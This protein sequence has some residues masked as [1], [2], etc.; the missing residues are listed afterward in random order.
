MSDIHPIQ[1]AL[2]ELDKVRKL[3]SLS[4]REIG[5][6]LGDSEKRVHPQVVK[7]HLNQLISSGKLSEVDRP[8]SVSPRKLAEANM[9]VSQLIRLPILGAA[10]AGPATT[11]A[12]STIEGY[13]SVSP[14]LLRSRNYPELIVLR[15]K[16]NSMNQAEINGL[17]I[18]NGDFVIVDKSRR[19]PRNREIVVV[20]DGDNRV[21]IKRIYF[22]P[23]NGQIDLLSESS[24]SFEPIYLTADED[25]DAFIEGTVVQVLKNPPTT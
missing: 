7:Y 9:G 19:T 14:A 16:G 6:Q 17:R 20:N 3:S 13:I 10:N 11:L 24:E 5:R 8:A 18:E 21:N 15:V 25:F 1:R 4:Y 23:E 12:K 22:R 2:L